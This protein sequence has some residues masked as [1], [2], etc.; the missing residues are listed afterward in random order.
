MIKK[1]LLGLLALVLLLGAA[2]GINTARKGSR[3]LAVEPIAKLA[4]D[5]AAVAQRLAEAVRLRTE[6]SRDDAGANTDQFQQFHALLQARFPLVHAK[7]KREVVG[8]L[9][10]LYTWPGSNA[11]A[12][13]VISSNPASV[14]PGIV[15]PDA[16]MLAP[17]CSVFHQWTEK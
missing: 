17:W 5:D 2:L 15:A 16:V 9:S 8:D 7:L 12:A 1:L 3:Q 4:V 6:S 13:P 10:L 14:A 11:Q